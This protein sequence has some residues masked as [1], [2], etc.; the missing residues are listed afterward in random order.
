MTLLA[1]ASA[2]YGMHLRG[3]SSVVLSP[4]LR[5]QTIRHAVQSLSKGSGEGCVV[6]R[7]GLASCL[8]LSKSH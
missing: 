3:P 4:N 5:V 8:L 7:I 1:R 2:R 6:V